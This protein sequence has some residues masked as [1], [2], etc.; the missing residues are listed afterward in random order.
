MRP[1]GAI[2]HI[3][4]KIVVS[5]FAVPTSRRALYELI[6]EIAGQ[7]KFGGVFLRRRRFATIF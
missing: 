6:Y 5:R 4:N 1:E 3:V 2:A 7:Q